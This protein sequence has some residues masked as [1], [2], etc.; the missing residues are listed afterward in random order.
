MIHA[1]VVTAPPTAP[2][3]RPVFVLIA[4]CVLMA[5][6]GAFAQKG[7]HDG[8]ITP[9]ARTVPL[10]LSLIAMEWGLVLYVPP[11]GVP[12]ASPRAPLRGRGRGPRPAV[13]RRGPGP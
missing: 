13:R 10:Y 4:V 2:N 5:V 12:G 11:P 8:A 7:A 3:R 1:E 9:P 6:G